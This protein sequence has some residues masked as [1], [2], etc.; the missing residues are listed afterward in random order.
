[1]T[2][3]AKTEAAQPASG[4]A[5][6][7][8]SAGLPSTSA[9]AYFHLLWDHELDA[10]ANVLDTILSRREQVLAHWHRLYLLHFGD[11][12]SLSDREFM[13][14]FGADLTATLGD[15]RAKDVDKFTSD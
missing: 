2:A 12:R 1:M 9:P 10:L 3:P 4:S 8:S 5:I 13:E 11:T 6:S 7:E 15:L 14:I